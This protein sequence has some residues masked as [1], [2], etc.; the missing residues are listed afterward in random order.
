VRKWLVG[1]VVGIAVSVGLG[2]AMVP[3]RPHLSIATAALVLVVPV[4]VGVAIGGFTAGAASVA[5]GFLVYDYGFIPPYNR[6]SVG[7]PQDWVALAVYAVVMLLVAQVVA[8][9]DT[10]RADA[11][12]RAVEPSA[13]PAVRTAGR[14]PFGGRVVEDHRPGRRQLL[15]RRRVALLVLEDGQLEI[16]STAGRRAHARRAG[17]LG[18]RPTGQSGHGSGGARPDPHGRPHR[19][20]SSGGMLAL[21]GIP[22]SE[23]DRAL[24]RTFA[25][26]AALALE[27][28][29]LRSRPSGPSC[30]RRWTGSATR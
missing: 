15:R 18:L 11:Q 5:A 24:L 29:R 3:M 14:G 19:L 2:A 9:L 30:W 23:S 13:W 16:A 10:A 21:R 6:L 26:H 8:R 7:R 28:A 25:N 1:S 17:P 20:G 4:V 12:R 27:Q 22:A